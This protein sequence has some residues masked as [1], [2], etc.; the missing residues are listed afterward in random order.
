MSESGT[1]PVGGSGF[2]LFGLR[3]RLEM[4]GGSLQI[5]S[6]KTKGVEAIIIAPRAKSN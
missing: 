2:G 6:R 5:H 1:T 3:E 4:L